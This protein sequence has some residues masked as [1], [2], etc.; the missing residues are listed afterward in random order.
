MRLSHCLQAAAMVLVL[1]PYVCVCVC[2][3][4]ESV[5]VPVRVSS[6]EVTTDSFR[7]S[8]KHAASDISLYRLSWTPANGGE[9]REVVWPHTDLPAKQKPY[10]CTHAHESGGF[11]SLFGI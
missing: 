4:V 11:I 1:C 9:T 7:V 6:S 2:V 10:T 8:W 3:F 5:P